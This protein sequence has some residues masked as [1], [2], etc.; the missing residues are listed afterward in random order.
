[1]RVIKSVQINY[2][3]IFG[4]LLSLGSVIALIPYAASS[5]LALGKHK[6]A[7][8]IPS[9]F[10]FASLFAYRSKSG[11]LDNKHLLYAFATFVIIAIP[12]FQLFN[13]P[14]IHLADDSLTYSR[15]A[16]YMIMNAT[17]EGEPNHHPFSEQIGYRYFIA[18]ELLI[19]GGEKVGMQTFNIGM[20]TVLNLLLLKIFIRRFDGS[21]LF[22]FMLFVFLINPFS[23]KN[24][25]Q[26]YSEWAT[27]SIFQVF[28][29]LRLSGA[30]TWG[31]YF[32]LGLI[33]LL[34]QNLLFIPLLVVILDLIDRKIRAIDLIVLAFVL[35]LP[36]LHNLHYY[37]EVRYLAGSQDGISGMVLP[38]EF[39][40][41]HSSGL[42]MLNF[43]EVGRN[44]FYLL[45]FI[46]SRLVHYLGI[47]IAT[48]SL[49]GVF[50]DAPMS[51]Y[52]YFSVLVGTIFCPFVTIFLLVRIPRLPVKERIFLI[53]LAILII[54]PTIIFGSGN[55]PR[56]QYMNLTI[57]FLFYYYFIYSVA[58]ELKSKKLL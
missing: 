30:K 23:V 43:E 28:I 44:F 20:F 41:Y 3:V 39:V 46:F 38:H 13:Q 26:G 56:F 34:R 9:F 24:I 27:Y 33:P 17:M 37:S 52:D 5:N 51:H 47:P 19:F 8:F 29:L 58:P 48:Y 40:H 15:A 16:H 32:V 10:A 36:L 53:V 22:I 2:I 21:A 35:S 45:K 31:S 12:L 42:P 18:A 55:F 50:I 11:S 14:V 54:S 4:L 25:L 6:I 49:N 7:F 1:M 57:L